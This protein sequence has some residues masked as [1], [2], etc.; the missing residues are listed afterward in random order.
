MIGRHWGLSAD[1][2]AATRHHHE[3]A[4][5][6]ENAWAAAVVHVADRVSV[7]V[8]LGLTGEYRFSAALD[9]KSAAILGLK[10]EVIVD[11]AKKIREEATEMQRAYAAFVG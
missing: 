1:Q 7:R 2:L 9:P 6:G 5:A 11:C 3:P 10:P 8:G 4:A